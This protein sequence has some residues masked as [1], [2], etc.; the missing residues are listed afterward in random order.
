MEV[1]SPSKY[2]TL[3]VKEYKGDSDLYKYVCYFEQKMLMISVPMAKLEAMKCKTF[4]Q[5]LAGPTLL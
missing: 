1:E 4:T 2:T 3:K 5:G